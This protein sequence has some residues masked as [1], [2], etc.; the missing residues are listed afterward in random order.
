MDFQKK[1]LEMQKEVVE[2]KDALRE[3]KETYKNE[4]GWKKE[5]TQKIQNKLR[6]NKEISLCIEN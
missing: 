3:L 2:Y 6:S 5:S 4:E 1:L